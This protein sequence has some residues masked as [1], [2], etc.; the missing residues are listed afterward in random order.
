MAA[1]G[2]AITEIGR[3][4]S[5]M[6]A[7]QQGFA[8]AVEVG[9]TASS[10]A[11]SVAMDVVNALGPLVETAIAEAGANTAIAANSLIGL[12]ASVDTEGILAV[13]KDTGAKLLAVLEEAIAAGAE[14]SGDVLDAAKAL[15]SDGVAITV[16]LRSRSAMRSVMRR[17]LFRPR[18][19]Q[20]SRSPPGRWKY[21]YRGFGAVLEAIKDAYGD[22]APTMA[23]AAAGLADAADSLYQSVDMSAIADVSKEAGQNLLIILAAAKDAGV[24]LHKP[25]GK[26]RR[27]AES[28]PIL[29]NISEQ[30][31]PVIKEI[32]GQISTEVVGAFLGACGS[33]VQAMQLWRR[34]V[35]PSK[36]RQV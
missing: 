34:S 17:I 22:L 18:A 28:S 4:Q 12:A 21:R 31:I 33:Q 20:H 13:A 15:A 32:G 23:L 2:P 35:T 36:K 25:S 26:P 6:P 1:I 14:V 7:V 30:V 10:E 24:E 5:A 16:D 27:S 8:T 29:K 3:V 11:A 9:G 19:S